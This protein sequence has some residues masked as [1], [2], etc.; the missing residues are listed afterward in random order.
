MLEGKWFLFEFEWAARIPAEFEPEE[1]MK[2]RLI[3]AE[4]AEVIRELEEQVDM[5]GGDLVFLLSE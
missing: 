2:V 5:I 4:G 3:N 1:G